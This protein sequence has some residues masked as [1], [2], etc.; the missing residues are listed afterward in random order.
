MFRASKAAGFSGDEHCTVSS[1]QVSVA[2]GARGCVGI[3]FPTSGG[4]NPIGL[5]A[6]RASTEPQI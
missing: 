6:G 2:R 1:G 4:W 3:K 5:A